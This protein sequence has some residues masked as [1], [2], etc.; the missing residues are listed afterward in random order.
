MKLHHS[1]GGRPELI[2]SLT[3]A[4]SSSVFFPR[5][6]STPP[7]LTHRPGNLSSMRAAGQPPGAAT[8]TAL[9][10]GHAYAPVSL[11]GKGNIRRVS[12]VALSGSLPRTFCSSPALLRWWGLAASLLGAGPACRGLIADVCYGSDMGVTVI[13]LH[14]FLFRWSVV[15]IFILVFGLTSNKKKVNKYQTCLGGFQPQLSV[16]LA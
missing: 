3:P 12:G 6:M 1:L 11:K 16:Y 8:P 7:P 5:P 9:P 2:T 13:A 4:F 14:L 10:S 15:K